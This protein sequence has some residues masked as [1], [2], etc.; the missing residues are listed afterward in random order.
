LFFLLFFSFL[1]SFFVLYS[2]L[3]FRIPSEV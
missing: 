3:C 2:C 1:F